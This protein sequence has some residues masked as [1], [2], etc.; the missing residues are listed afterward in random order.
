MGGDSA[1]DR[2]R[3]RNDEDEQQSQQEEGNRTTH[4]CKE[5][6]LPGRKAQHQQAEQLLFGRVPVTLRLRHMLSLQ[7]IVRS[8]RCIRVT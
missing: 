8:G 7:V 3:S 6:R 4:A 5:E 2:W 1:V